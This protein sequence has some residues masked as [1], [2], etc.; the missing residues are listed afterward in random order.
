MKRFNLYAGEIVD[1]SPFKDCIDRIESN[2]KNN[3]ANFYETT[4]GFS[5]KDQ[6]T[7]CEIG[8][9]VCM[10]SHRN[11]L[12]KDKVR[13]FAIHPMYSAAFLS[14]YSVSVLSVVAAMG[15]D[16]IEEGVSQ[17]GLKV[18][19]EDYELKHA[20]VCIGAFMQYYFGIKKQMPNNPLAFKYFN[21]V[22]RIIDSMTKKGEDTYFCSLQNICFIDTFSMK[23]RWT[24]RSAVKNR[25][26][27]I[28]YLTHYFNF[29][30]ILSDPNCFPSS[31]EDLCK[32][33]FKEFYNITQKAEVVLKNQRRSM[34]V[35]LADIS[36]NIQDMP[37]EFPFK[38]RMSL[39]TKS[40]F[41]MNEILNYYN[42]HVNVVNSKLIFNIVKDVALQTKESLH[43]EIVAVEERIGVDKTREHY[44]EL[45]S[46]KESEHFNN[47]ENNSIDNTPF[48][49]VFSDQL[50][51][52]VVGEKFSLTDDVRIH[53]TLIVY[54]SV[55]DKHFLNKHFV[56]NATLNN[57]KTVY[58]SGVHK[59][60]NCAFNSK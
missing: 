3:R 37:P 17:I 1:L 25:E 45:N 50:F 58:E 29:D 46:Y 36:Y 42:D 5:F 31:L 51:S 22:L 49:Q 38:S 9:A 48:A 4:H 35:K 8:A 56:S 39:Y 21:S 52:L 30:S 20:A 27:I 10:V 6:I 7:S 60:K 11:Q 55:I 16:I 24:F 18:G 53:R 2:L 13:D 54:N 19:D 40:M 32:H 47:L 23:D 14:S 34:M 33:F 57:L 43:K 26:K 12:R 28:K 41:I 59:S 44:A 15:H